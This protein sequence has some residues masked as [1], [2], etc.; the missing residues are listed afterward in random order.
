MLANKVKT[1]PDEHAERHAGSPRHAFTCLAPPPDRDQ[2][3]EIDTNME[4]KF[5]ALRKRMHSR[6]QH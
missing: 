5:D 3:S 2:I 6:V 1:A 4:S